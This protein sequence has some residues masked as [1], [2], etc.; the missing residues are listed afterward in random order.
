MGGGGWNAGTD[1]PVKV[2][3]MFVGKSEFDPKGDRYGRGLNLFDPQRY[4]CKTNRQMR[5][6]VTETDDDHFVVI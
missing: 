6:N 1:S 3:G 4:H 2:T 5:A